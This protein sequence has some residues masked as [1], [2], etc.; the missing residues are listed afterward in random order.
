MC[1]TLELLY[2]AGLSENG[3]KLH[4]SYYR[5][6]KQVVCF[7][8]ELKSLKLLIKNLQKHNQSWAKIYIVSMFTL[9]TRPPDHVM[10]AE[11]FI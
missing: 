1:K 11:V 10:L 7:V 2:P 5:K 3:G 8:S 6:S 9:L 4:T